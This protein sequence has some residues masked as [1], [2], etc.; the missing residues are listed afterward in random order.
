MNRKNYTLLNSINNFPS[1]LGLSRRENIR[2]RIVQRHRLGQSL[3]PNNNN[4]TNRANRIDRINRTFMNSSTRVNE[5]LRTQ[6]N[7]ENNSLSSNISNNI[8]IQSNFMSRNSHLSSPS[9][10]LSNIKI[11]NK[12]ISKFSI[13]ENDLNQIEE[14]KLKDEN[15]TSEIKDTV[16]CYICFNTITNPKMCPRCHRIACEKCLYNWFMVEHK[17]ACGFCREN[18]NFYEMISVP[19]MSTVVDFVEKVFEKDKDGEIKFSEKFQDFCS[20]HPNEQLYYY[21]LDCNKGYC[22][23][24]FV[25]FGEEKDRHLN[26]NIIE[27]EKYKNLNFTSLKVYEDKINSYINK[28]KE[29]IKKCES[30]KSAYE[31]ERNEGNKLIDNLRKEFNIQID[32]N[33]RMIDEQINKLQKIIDNYEKYTIELN[34]YYS[35]FSNE[36]ENKN[37]IYPYQK[38]SQEL[39]NKLSKMTSRKFYSNKEIEKLMDLS[40]GIHVD[41]YLSKIGEFNHETRFL[42]KSLKMGDSPY[43]LVID[44]KQR[45]EVNINL[46]IPKNK[47]TFEHNFKAFILIRKK[48][49]E[50][51]TYEL[52]EA[53]EDNNYFYFRKKIP[54]D[55]FGES[56]FKIRGILYDYYFL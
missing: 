35:K 11:E 23:T 50:A 39:I 3:E 38:M 40:K 26:H 17:K 44:N 27:Y 52:E 12:K 32:D 42:S 47:I 34:N 22:K 55:Y 21:C 18:I 9:D 10:D 49:N 25:F 48:G 15:I 28:T 5:S 29:K 4:R 30:Y 33:I 43:Q 54:W 31:F 41:S 7:N 1:T 13:N 45:N 36:D 14:E 24:C 56:I 37:N 20:N 51:A 8:N 6:P 2:M 53:K 16:K 46:V 19:F